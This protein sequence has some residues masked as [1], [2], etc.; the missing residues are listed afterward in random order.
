MT[1][2]DPSNPK[3]LNRTA[4]EEGL[5]FD[6]LEAVPEEANPELASEIFE[7][8][9]QLLDQ[10]KAG[11]IPKVVWEILKSSYNELSSEEKATITEEEYSNKYINSLMQYL[12]SSI[13]KL[14]EGQIPQN[15]LSTLF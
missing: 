7:Q 11:N 3:E 8:I 6:P 9:S 14:K 12:E 15:L 13:P 1:W 5:E 2:L 10:L 4:L